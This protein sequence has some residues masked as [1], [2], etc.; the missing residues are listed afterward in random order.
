MVVAKGLLDTGLAWKCDG[1]STLTFGFRAITGFFMQVVFCRTRNRDATLITGHCG[2][3][4]N[5][6]HERLCT[7]SQLIVFSVQPL[8]PRCLCG[9]FLLR[10][11]LTTEDTEVAQ[12][13][14]RGCTEKEFD[15]RLSSKDP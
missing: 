2:P 4:T 11:Q 15:K 9:E 14:H 7:K 8:C 13:L 12:R 6:S 10:I 5:S 1:R 3:A